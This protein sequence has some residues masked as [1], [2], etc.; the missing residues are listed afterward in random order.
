[1]L[2]ERVGTGG[3]LRGE[4]ETGEPSPHQTELRDWLLA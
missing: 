3:E 4:L 2:A 1:V